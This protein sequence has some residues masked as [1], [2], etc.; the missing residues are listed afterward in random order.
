[1]GRADTHSFPTVPRAE[2]DKPG[3]T[4]REKRGGREGVEGRGVEGEDRGEAW[5]KEEGEKES[6]G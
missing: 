2:M 3:M 4:E 1:M 6:G 5:M